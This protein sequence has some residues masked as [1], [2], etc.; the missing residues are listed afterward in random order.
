MLKI[1]EISDSNNTM[2]LKL[3]GKITNQWVAVLEKHVAKYIQDTK[4]DIVLDF[5]DISYVSKE[6]ITLLTSIQNNIKIIN[7]QPYIQLCL[8]NR[9]IENIINNGGN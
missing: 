2:I 7:A 1:S 5:A 8:K 9:G 6:G 4:S 3:E